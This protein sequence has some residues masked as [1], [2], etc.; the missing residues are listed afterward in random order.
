MSMTF[1]VNLYNKY[2]VRRLYIWLFYYSFLF[3][4]LSTFKGLT[5]FDF[6]EK[7]L[8]LYFIVFM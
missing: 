3:F 1:G 4:L 2:N 5:T 7:Q 6:K 8:M